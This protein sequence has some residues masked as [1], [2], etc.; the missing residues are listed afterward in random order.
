VNQAITKPDR[1]VPE[2]IGVGDEM[3]VT[4]AGALDATRGDFEVFRKSYPRRV[5]Q[6]KVKWC[7]LKAQC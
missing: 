7:F 3:N 4:G 5:L 6:Q 1:A 2:G